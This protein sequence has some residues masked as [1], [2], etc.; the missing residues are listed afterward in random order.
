MVGLL[1]NFTSEQLAQFAAKYLGSQDAS[2][3]NM[4]QFQRGEV[5]VPGGHDVQVA[6]VYATLALTE[7]IRELSVKL[8]P[9]QPTSPRS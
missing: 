3:L 1:N 9:K 8:E 2:G 5:S 4:A 6:Q 7:A